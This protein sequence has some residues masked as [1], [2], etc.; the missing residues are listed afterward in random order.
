MGKKAGFI[1]LIV[2]GIMV[3]G[4]SIYNN[5]VI[6]TFNGKVPFNKGEVIEYRAHYGF[7]NAAIAKMVISENVF[8]IN[9]KNCYKIDVYGKSVGMFDLMLSI[10][11][12][13]GTYLDTSEM[14]PQR[15]W[16]V[17]KEGRYR[18][19]EI[20]DFYQKEQKAEVITYNFKQ[21]KWNEKKNFD[22]PLK[23]QDMVS[24]YYYLR[25]LD[26]SKL[27]KGDVIVIDGFFDNETYNFKIRYLGRDQLKT[28]I[29]T[30]N[31]HFFAPIMPKNDLFKG[32]NSI[33]FWLSDDEY[34]IPLKIRAEMFVGAVELDITDYKP[35]GD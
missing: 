10:D 22:I 18:K 34:K 9:G 31:T 21:D 16:R 27:N 24:G 6:T 29:G 19:H 26:M 17:L 14:L 15:F 32:E 25:T 5:K 11:D 12:N 2:A 8:Q 33:K 1:F 28:K 23:S 20:V 4:M 3:T 35:Y 7:L 30:Y 13:W